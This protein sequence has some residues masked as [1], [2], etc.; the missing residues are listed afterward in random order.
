MNPA[1]CPCHA[2]HEE[3]P[4]ADEKDDG[5]NPGKEVSQNG[6]FHLAFEGDV[7]LFEKG[8]Y[9]RVYA[10]GLEELI[11]V[12]SLSSILI[13]PW[14]WL[15]EIATSATRFSLTRVRNWL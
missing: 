6:R 1:C 9:L 14:I 15:A 4:D 10:Q 7:V 8:G 3:V 5:K 2:F 11:L 13:L 12:G